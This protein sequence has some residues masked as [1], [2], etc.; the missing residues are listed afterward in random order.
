MEIHLNT[1]ALGPKFDKT[2]THTHTLGQSVP[3]MDD[4]YQRCKAPKTEKLC[5]R[6]KKALKKNL[7]PTFISCFSPL[8]SFSHFFFLKF[9]NLRDDVV[10]PS[11]NEM[12]RKP[13]HKASPSMLLIYFTRTLLRGD[14]GVVIVFMIIIIVVVIVVVVIVI[15]IVIV[16][17]VVSAC[18]VQ[19]I[20][21]TAVMLLVRIDSSFQHIQ[22]IHAHCGHE[23]RRQRAHHVQLQRICMQ[24]IRENKVLEPKHD[25]QVR[26]RPDNDSCCRYPQT[27]PVAKLFLPSV[28]KRIAQARVR[29][30]RVECL[31]SRLDDIKRVGYS[32][33][34]SSTKAPDNKALPHRNAVVV[35]DLLSTTTTTSTTTTSTT[36]IWIHIR[37]NQ[38]QQGLVQSKPEKVERGFAQEG[39]AQATMRESEPSSLPRLMHIPKR[40]LGAVTPHMRLHASNIKR[41]GD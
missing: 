34:H 36:I 15:V 20:Q 24:A 6:R 5:E 23:P 18:S 39:G 3:F 14:G 26:S 11:P 28:C 30:A 32:R 9:Y 41:A 40:C 13:P 22:R 12:P 1:H 8:L 19:K 16:V 31:V 37:V 7:S 29:K 10:R 27:P 21:I 33:P 35:F 17:I 38:P 25:S 4:R 2:H